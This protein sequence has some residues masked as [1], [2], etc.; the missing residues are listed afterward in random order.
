MNK[1]LSAGAELIQGNFN[2][3]LKLYSQPLIPSV[4][5]GEDSLKP[6]DS[7]HF[8]GAGFSSEYKFCYSDSKSAMSAY[9]KCSP[10][11]SIINRKT[12]ADLNGKRY[13]MD[14][15]GKEATNDVADRIRALLDKPNII[16]NK[17][18]FLAQLKIYLQIYS[19]AVVFCKPPAG[20]K[21]RYYASSMWLLPNQHLE[22]ITRNIIPYNAK[23]LSDFI[24]KINFVVNGVKYPVDLDYIYIFTDN[25]AKNENVFPI[26]RIRLLEDPISNVI[27]A[28]NSRGTLISRRG[29][30]GI[31][32]PRGKDGVGLSVALKPDEKKSLQDEWRK[33]GTKS[34][35]YNVVISNSSIDWTRISMDV[36]ELKLMEEVVDS[37][38]MLCDGYGFPPYLLGLVDPTFN[39]QLAAEKSLYQ[40]TIIPEAEN[41]DVQWNDFFSAADSKL[42]L[43]T[44]FAHLPV[45]QENKA[46]AATARKTLGEELEREF[47]LNLITYNRFLE[48]L[49]EDTVTTPEGEMY[50]YQLQKIGWYPAPPSQQPAPQATQTPQEQPKA[51]VVNIYNKFDQGEAR[52]SSGRWTDGGSTGEWVS[53]AD[54]PARA[55]ELNIPPAWTDV[56]LNSK[57]EA[58][59]LATGFDS[60]GRKQYIYSENATMRQAEAK[61]ARNQELVKKQNYIFNQNETNISSKDFSTAE[62]ASAMSV[63]LE[64]GI[65]PG[66][67]RETFAKVKAYGATTLEGR[68][69]VEDGFGGVRLQFV[70]KKGVNIDVP[71]KDKKIAGML[72]DRKAKVGNEGKLFETDD[73]ELRKYAKKLN[74]GSFK[75]K[76]FRTLKGT[77]T[78]IQYLKGVKPAKDMNEYKKIVSN[79]AKEVSKV[80]GN[81]PSIALKSYINPFVFLKIKPAI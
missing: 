22:I 58:D 69:V 60:K 71:V 45:M 70:G 29:A 34:D 77:N 25:V 13:V 3:A 30:L 46:E 8:W 48:L 38:K 78:A 57:R 43:I 2:N 21:E 53:G 11:S 59:L 50:Y 35:Q 63:I 52:D 14:K 80:L 42:K 32:S 54:D 20:M 17:S 27:A 7:W 56:K 24:E 47:K 15:K 5:R 36:G 10:L 44:D 16:Q 74:G 55:K 23:K 37:S 64:T 4:Y 67:A 1:L 6:P 39:N 31:I 12:Q 81:T 73:S 40:N 33:Y 76:D 61:F 41:I 28:M 9:L 62:N 49:D 65:R 66:S 79:T 26:S 51:A 72:L 18:S 19:Y 68:H 75:P